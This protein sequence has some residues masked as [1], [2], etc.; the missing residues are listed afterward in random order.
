MYNIPFNR[1]VDTVDYVHPTQDYATN[2]IAPK[3][4]Q[5]IEEKFGR[6]YYYDGC[7][8]CTEHER[9]YYDNLFVDTIENH[10]KICTYD[11]HTKQFIEKESPSNSYTLIDVTGMKEIRFAFTNTIPSAAWSYF[12]YD[13]NG[14]FVGGS[15]MPS[16]LI[17]VYAKV[18]TD[19]VCLAVLYSPKH[20]YSVYQSG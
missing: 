15:N 18:P 12:F 8:R 17:D 6:Y 7:F 20:P 1:L 10:G 14:K 16:G 3:I 5:F 4:A 19:A 11:L 9:V 13:E 2:V